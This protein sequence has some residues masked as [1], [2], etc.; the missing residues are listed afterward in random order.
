MRIGLCYDLRDDYIARGFTLEAASE[1]DVPET[2]AALTEAIEAEGHVVEPIGALPDLVGA[3]AAGRRWP[4]VFNIAEGVAGI[5]REAQVP[6]LLEAYGIPFTFSS[7]DVLVVAM[8]KSL[9]KRVVRGAGVASP[10]FVVVR[11]V[12]D[13]AGLALP[14]PL[15]V[16]PLA[17]G[18]SKGVFEHSRIFDM[19][20]LK[21]RVEALL[22]AYRQPVLVETYLPGREFTVGIL[23]TGRAARA[24]GVAEIGTRAGG[25]QAAYSHRNKM[26][27]FDE[28]TLAKGAL[29]QAAA[30]TALAAW[31]ALGARDAGRVDIR[32]DRHGRPAFIEANPLAGLRPDWSELP[33]LS[34]LSGM[35]Y[36]RLIG[37]ILEEAVARMRA[38]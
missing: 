26:E 11:E 8:D 32:C 35:T 7:A 14:F 6:A 37:A 17:E 24:I 18:T 27:G 25:D 28:L 19:R 31:R 3:L 33:I 20:M 1:F 30:D 38:T 23:G 22:E 4:L 10:D 36:Q 5:A 34:K 2:I 12:A 13:L 16:K 15:F 29:A 21:D 9:A